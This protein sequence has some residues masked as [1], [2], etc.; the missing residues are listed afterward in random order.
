MGDDFWPGGPAE[1]RRLQRESEILDLEEM[2]E[3]TSWEARCDEC[4]AVVTGVEHEAVEVTRGPDWASPARWSEDMHR[5][6]AQGPHRNVP[7]GHGA[8]I[9]TRPVA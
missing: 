3:P 1:G 9:T 5:Q 6:F 7:C 4:G 8:S 2:Y